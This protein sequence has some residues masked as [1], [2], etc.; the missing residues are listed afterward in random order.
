MTSGKNI[1]AILILE[2]IGRPP[3]HLIA[4]LE[5]LIKEMGKEKGVSVVGKKINEPVLMKDQKDFYTTFAE[6]EVTV[7][8]I[9][10]LAMLMFKY[11]PA[12]IEV[13]SPEMIPVSNN[14]WSE[15][16]SELTRRLHA[17]DEVARVIAVEKDILEKR[18]REVLGQGAAEVGKIDGKEF[19][20][21]SKE[22]KKTKKRAKK[23]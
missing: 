15:V 13:I 6:I 22:P 14:G 5:D 2:I 1:Q 7:E 9:L 20:E 23:K 17:Y 18:L 12:H 3:E 8:D 21:E 16:L 4:S 11:M 10:L 19:K